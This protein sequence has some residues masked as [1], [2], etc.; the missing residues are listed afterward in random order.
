MQFVQADHAKDSRLRFV[1]NH[2]VMSFS[3]ASDA[4]FG[5][6]ALTLDDISNRRHGNP[7]AIDV[8]LKQRDAEF[9]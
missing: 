1:F 3:L 4:T 5:E 2:S 8:R 6:I 7:L 9:R